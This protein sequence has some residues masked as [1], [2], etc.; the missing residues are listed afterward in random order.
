MKTSFC[1]A[2]YTAFGVRSGSM[3]RNKAL[4]G[5]IASSHSIVILPPTRAGAPTSHSLRNKLFR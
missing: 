3:T 2:V 4:G 5:G 1:K